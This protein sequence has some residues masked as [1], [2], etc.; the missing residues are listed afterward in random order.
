MA[1]RHGNFWARRAAGLTALAHRRQ[2][3]VKWLVF[4]ALALAWFGFGLASWLAQDDP[5]GDAIYKT[6][7]ALTIQG[8]YEDVGAKGN[9]Y[10]DIARFAGVFVPLV[11]ILFAFSGQLGRG[12]A[13]LFMAGASRHVVIVGATPA[14]LSLA[15]S[16]VEGRDA[17]ALIA[18]D[19]SAES[20]WSVRQAGVVLY[21]GDGADPTILRTA[22]AHR[23]DH[24]IALCEDDSTNLKVEAALRTAANRVRRN[25][26]IAAHIAIA[27]PLLLI[28]AREMR[29]KLQR[30]RDAKVKQA[31]EEKRPPPPPDPIDPRPF[32]LAELAARD[33]LSR[34]AGVLLNYAEA[35]A[36]PR[37]HLVLFGFDREAEAVAVRAL[38]GL[39]SAHFGEP[40]IT[41]VT[42]DPEAADG[43]FAAR[44]PQALTHEVWRAD[45]A[46]IRFDWRE[47]ALDLEFLSFVEDERGPVTAAI[48]STGSDTETI[49]L[50]FALLRTA[51]IAKRWP[52]PI[53]LKESARSEFT[54]QFANGDR[55]PG[56]ADAYLQAFGGVESVASR[57][58]I[59][60]GML[61]AG[62]AVAH[63]V[64]QEGIA[65]RADVDRRKLEAMGRGWD[66]VPETYRAANRAAADSAM[67]KMWD[68]GWRAARREESGVT[69]PPIDP[70]MMLKMAE[71]EH[72]RWIAERLLSGWRPG[73]DR[74]NTMMVHDN[75][76]PWRHLNQELRERDVEQVKAAVM[77]ARIMHPKGFAPD[78]RVL[79]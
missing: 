34:E 71:I 53:Y 41:V 56:V 44:Y 77:V 27:S 36:Q 11:G 54:A 72:K 47:R 28:E 8:A 1:S 38:M 58:L 39:W 12:L 49:Q 19:L 24:F 2:P 26:P 70:A 10:A 29:Q 48:A 64:Y 13:G 32:S 66:D 65:A 4:V 59:I 52:V 46:Y 73:S 33:L 18:A 22:R 60:N 57:K 15:R 37:P 25:Q 7:G 9:V 5:P 74:N 75:I 68:L 63:R 21:D 17:V 35:N 43:V 76:T 51:N 61:D 20:A 45:I 62:A 69:S 78:P 31:R 23:A 40:R 79:G 67:V 50:A 55:T 3:H 14:A 16:C 42:P 6:L 30:D